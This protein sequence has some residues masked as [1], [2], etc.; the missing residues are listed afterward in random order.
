MSLMHGYGVRTR[1]KVK[2]IKE[3]TTARHACPECGKTS[4]KRKSTGIWVCRSCGAE[5][6]G[7]AFSPQSEVG[8]AARKAV[9]SV[10]RA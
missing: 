6:A 10:K 4:V 9:D 3:Q 1:N 2:A 8:A 7:A 5:F